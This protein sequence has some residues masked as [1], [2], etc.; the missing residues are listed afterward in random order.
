MCTIRTAES[1]TSAHRSQSV[2]THTAESTIDAHP[3]QTESRT[4]VHSGRPAA[5]R[6]YSEV[7]PRLK[8]EALSTTY[9]NETA[10]LQA[11]TPAA[12]HSP[13]TQCAEMGAAIHVL[14]MDQTEVMCS[15]DKDLEALISAMEMDT[16]QDR[17]I[18]DGL[19]DQIED[20]DGKENANR[21]GGLYTKLVVEKKD[22]NMPYSLVSLASVDMRRASA[23]ALAMQALSPTSFSPLTSSILPPAADALELSVISMSN[24]LSAKERA[25]D[26]TVTNIRRDA[27]LGIDACNKSVA[28]TDELLEAQINSISA[29]IGTSEN[30]YN[31]SEPPGWNMN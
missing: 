31:F 22:I 12:D 7:T 20:T 5:S 30:S 13:T 10:I 26:L 18:S 15:I 11:R 23:P 25:E 8:R 19:G 28:D 27:S 21:S 17:E 4:H 14:Q 24:F 3:S 6:A 16:E 9:C 29:S 2:S 1:T